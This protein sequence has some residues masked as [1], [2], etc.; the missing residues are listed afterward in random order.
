[1]GLALSSNFLHVP[2]PW[3]INPK[4]HPDGDWIMVSITERERS[5]QLALWVLRSVI[6]NVGCQLDSDKGIGKASF[7]VSVKA[8]LERINE[9]GAPALNEDSN[10]QYVWELDGKKGRKRW[11]AWCAIPFLWGTVK[12]AVA[13]ST[14]YHE[15][16]YH[17]DALPCFEPKVIELVWSHDTKLNFPLWGLY[18][19]YFITA[20]KSLPNTPA[21]YWAVRIWDNSLKLIFSGCCNYKQRNWNVHQALWC[22]YHCAIYI[23]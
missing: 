23:W 21:M 2:H 4:R 3:K 17:C 19:T 16:K 7:G 6:T 20:T 5:N 9:E 8:F 10:I 15:W 13:L 11:L 14:H 12:W 22:L 1:M 18:D